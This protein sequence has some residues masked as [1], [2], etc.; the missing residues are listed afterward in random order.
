MRG[1]ATA[2]G[3]DP[4]PGTQCDANA[5]M[6]LIGRP[7]DT[8]SA[9][10]KRLSGAGIVRRYRTGDAVTMDLPPPT[11]SMWKPTPRERSSS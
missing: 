4:A 10:A 3:R 1:A 2:A 8:A 9:E 11:G 7:A 5:A 6:A